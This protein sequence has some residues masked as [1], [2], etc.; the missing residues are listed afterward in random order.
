MKPFEF[1]R[2]YC[3]QTPTRPTDAPNV[4]WRTRTASLDC[5]GR[6]DAATRWRCRP[7]RNLYCARRTSASL[8]TRFDPFRF[9]R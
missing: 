7:G 2:A 4:S 8:E 9:A 6:Y 5:N 1:L 3:R